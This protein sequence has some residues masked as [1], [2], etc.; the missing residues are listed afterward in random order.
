M[1]CRL[2]GEVRNPDDL[3]ELLIAGN[4]AITEI[5]AERGWPDALYDPDPEHRGSIYTRRG[6]FISHVDRFEAGFFR[7][8]PQEVR[9]AGA[10]HTLPLELRG[11]GP[12]RAA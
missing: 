10:Q 12:E 4:E 11:G 7:M 1:A 3:F 2:P 5:P 6:G 8:S 9:A